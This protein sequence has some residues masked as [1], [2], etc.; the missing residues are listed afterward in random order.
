ML[1]VSVHM[2]KTW[3][4]IM[5]YWWWKWS[6]ISCKR[7]SRKY[8]HYPTV[9]EGVQNCWML[10]LC[11]GQMQLIKV[12]STIHLQQYNFF[13]QCVFATSLNNYTTTLGFTC[14]KIV[15]KGGTLFPLTLGRCHGFQ[16]SIFHVD[17]NCVWHLNITKLTLSKQRLLYIY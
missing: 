7:P 6:T 17:V 13:N 3:R 9:Y 2:K 5:V 16:D 8:S 15:K 12:K 14:I 11:D 1:M 10:K 4:R